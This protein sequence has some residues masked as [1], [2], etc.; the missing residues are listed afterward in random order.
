VSAPETFARAHDRAIRASSKASALSRRDTDASLRSLGEAEQRRLRT[1]TALARY[2]ET[3]DALALTFA[4][5]HR[6]SEGVAS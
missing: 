1:A 5:A 6:R 2:A 4:A 3:Q